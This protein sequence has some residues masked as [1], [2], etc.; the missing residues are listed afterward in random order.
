AHILRL[1]VLEESYRAYAQTIFAMEKFPNATV[2]AK[3]IK[4]HKPQTHN[5][6]LVFEYLS[7]ARS[8]HPGR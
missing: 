5:A 6:K 8:A 3:A 1:P 4:A 2:V 7:S